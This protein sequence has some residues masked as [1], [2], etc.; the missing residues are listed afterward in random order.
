MPTEKL[1]KDFMTVKVIAVT[2][3]TPLIKAVDV[4]LKNRFNG[5]PVVDRYGAVVG[6]LTQFDLTIKGSSIH[7]PHIFKID[8]G[9]SDL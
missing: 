9:I 4:L 3:E 2:P 7:L 1:L 6:V 5:L 8:H